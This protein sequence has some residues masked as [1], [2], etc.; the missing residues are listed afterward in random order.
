MTRISRL[1]ATAGKE[2][3]PRDAVPGPALVAPGNPDLVMQVPRNDPR[4]FL[5]LQ[6]WTDERVP[7]THMEDAGVLSFFRIAD[8][9]GL[10]AERPE[11]GGWPM[12]GAGRPAAQGRLTGPVPGASGPDR[13]IRQQEVARCQ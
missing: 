1:T 9:K 6:R 11:A 8:E 4:Y 10:I 5:L 13:T 2:N 3:E 12:D 7:Q